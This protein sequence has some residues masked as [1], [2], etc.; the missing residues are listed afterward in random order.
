MGASVSVAATVNPCKDEVGKAKCNV[1][2]RDSDRHQTISAVRASENQISSTVSELGLGLDL[3]FSM[4]LTHTGTL[5][6]TGSWRGSLNPS[7]FE[8]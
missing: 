4:R 5:G 6:V 3:V 8:R 1:D 2:R 7:L